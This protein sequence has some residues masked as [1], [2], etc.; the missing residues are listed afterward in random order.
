[1]DP[2]APFDDDLVVDAASE[3]GPG[4]D[5]VASALRAHQ[6]SVREYPGVDDLVYEW[7]RGMA[8]DPLVTRGDVAYYLVVLDHV[9]TEFGERL[10]FADDLLAAV[11][12]VHDRQARRDAPGQDVDPAVYDEAAPV[13]LTRC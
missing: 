2:L 5:G 1:M 13:V 10:G 11:R 7:R 9:W 4:A 3:A 8:S 12:R 6:E